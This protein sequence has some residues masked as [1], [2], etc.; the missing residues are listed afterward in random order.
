MIMHLMKPG[1]T[2]ASLRFGLFV[3]VLVLAFGSSARAALFGI[4]E[5]QEIEAGKQVRQQAYKEYGKPLPP[6]NPMSRRVRVIG[7]RFA[8]LSERKN[9]PYSYEVLNNE[10][11]LN[12]F[13]APGGPVFVTKKLMETVSN[14]AELAYVLGH[15]TAH[16]DRKHIVTAVAKQQKISLGV[17]IL[18][19]ILGYNDSNLFNVLSNAAFTV[20]NQGYSRDQESQADEYGVRW[21]SQLGFDPNAAISMLKKLDT[22]GSGGALDKY[23]SSHPDPK[24]REKAVAKEIADENLENVARQHGGPSL[25]AHGLPA[26]QGVDKNFS[27]DNYSALAS[28]SAQPE[29]LIAVQNG[30]H[31][32]VLAAVRSFADWAGATLRANGKTITITHGNNSI[33]LREGSRDAVLNGRRKTLSAAARVY[34]GSLYAPVGDLADGVGGNVTWD[35]ERHGVNITVGNKSTF[36]VLRDW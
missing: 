5:Q 7:M 13:A 34:Q 25:S 10:K 33:Q 36:W 21:M 29:S 32:V 15:E 19:A 4:S 30:D 26:F 28:N 6:D 24:A 12:A 2:M 27:N 17:G 14:D 9:I 18:G 1:K 3:A 8:H 22:G 31:K 11:I 23:L 35:A 20:W 16:I